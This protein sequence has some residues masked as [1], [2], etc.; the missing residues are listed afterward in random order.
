MKV[1][2]GF[3]V[4][5]ELPPVSKKGDVVA[6][7]SEFFGM[8]KT[9]LHRPD[10][11]TFA[12]IACTSNGKDVYMVTNETEVKEFLRRLKSA[13]WVY[14]NGKFDITQMRRYARIDEHSAL[15]D[16]MLIE[17]IMWSGYYSDFSLADLCRRYLGIYMNKD[18]REQFVTSTKLSKDE[19]TYAAADVVGTW[20]VQKEQAKIISK[21]DLWIW[22]NIEKNFLWVVTSMS[23]ITLDT[24]KWLANA[25]RKGKEAEAIQ[26]KYKKINLNAPGQVLTEMHRLG[27]KKLKNT[28]E[29]T[30]TPLLDQC[31]F[32]ADVLEYRGNAKHASTYGQK[33]VDQ[34]VE[35][36]GRIYGDLYS[37]GAKTGRTSARNPNMQ[38]QPHDEETRSCYVAGPGNVLVI[39][40]YSAQEPR[41]ASFLANDAKLLK[42]FK[43][44]KDIYIEIARDALGITM[45]KND[46][47]RKKIKSLIL[48][49]FYGMAAF[50]LAKKNDTTEEEAQDMID[51]VF[52]TYDG[53]RAYDERQRK[54]KAFVTSIYGRK[55]WLNHYLFGWER[56]ALNYPIQSSAGDALKIA[57]YRFLRAWEGGNLW[58]RSCLVL[59]VHDEIVI[60]VPKKDGKKAAD[61]LKKIMIQ[62]AQEM[63]PGIPGDVEIFIGPNWGIKS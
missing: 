55:I 16:T 51:K 24:K 14:Q 4:H 54:A 41:I 28:L 11:G 53:I 49:I 17:Q 40:D 58:K 6:I 20:L 32:A 35:K 42:I 22:N 63:H 18:V 15:W 57:S 37:I 23:G 43:A 3:K 13:T 25:E 10:N 9:R 44:K 19:E 39:S 52:N 38:N 12:S 31:K 27:Y 36:D 61:L 1:I 59:L 26:K 7:D 47:R 33:F 62:T 45:T 30:L 21:Q 60:E 50:G 48:G 46:K 2:S 5:H 29:D 8:T 34:H 56:D